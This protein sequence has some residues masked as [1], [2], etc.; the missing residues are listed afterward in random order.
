MT[1]TAAAAPEVTREEMH[2]RR[3]D[4]RGY[5][6]SD[7]LYEVEGR[8]TDRKPHDF[9]SPNGFKRVP[10]GQPI[11]DMGVALVFDE[12]MTVRA[13]RAFSESAPYD[14]CFEAPATLQVLVGLRLASGWGAEVR[15]HLS[16]AA[17]CSHLKEILVPMATV[18]YQTLTML[19]A[20]RP[21]ILNAQ[22]VPVKIDSCY[23][24]ARNRDVVRRKWPVHYT[25][26]AV[27]SD[28]DTGN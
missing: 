16:G 8:V 6:R 24:Y 9:T 1:Q 12:Q 11:H 14:S 28:E 19:R 5:R 2:F 15:K 27:V 13:V 3:I 23:A 18:A 21:D 17:C 7:G 4:M 26:P 10:A 20:A 25:G 22:G